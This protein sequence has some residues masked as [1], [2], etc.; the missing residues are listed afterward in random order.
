MASAVNDITTILTVYRRPHTLIEQLEAIQNQTYPPSSIIIWK[1]HYDNIVLPEIP[2]HLK[3]NVDIITSTRNF[4]V[5]A[6]FALGLL[7]NTNYVAVF[8]DDTIP[9]T[10]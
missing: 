6:R 7:A 5:W 2:E 1:N 8:D 4:G 9:G 3:K 10:K